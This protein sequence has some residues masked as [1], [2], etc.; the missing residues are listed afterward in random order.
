MTFH[1]NDKI[2]LTLMRPDPLSL[3]VN[4][5]PVS[6]TEEST[7]SFSFATQSGSTYFLDMSGDLT[8]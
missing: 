2:S 5:F 3:E 1:I 4:D 8:K 7:K 6:N